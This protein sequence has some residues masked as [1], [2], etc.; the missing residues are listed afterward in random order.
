MKLGNMSWTTKNKRPN[1][2]QSYEL[3]YI[4]TNK[5][6]FYNKCAAIV[7]KELSDEIIGCK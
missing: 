1:S 5:I 7:V 4:S 2:K 6:I 3:N